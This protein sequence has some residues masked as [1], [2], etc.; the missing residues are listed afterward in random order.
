MNNGT[1]Y[2]AENV[3]AKK[4]KFAVSRHKPLTTHAV[5]IKI[6]V[7]YSTTLSQRGK[8]PTSNAAYIPLSVIA[9]SSS[10]C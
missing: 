7:P 9:L 2:L 5:E 8:I 1:L 3:T 4:K 10:E 6:I